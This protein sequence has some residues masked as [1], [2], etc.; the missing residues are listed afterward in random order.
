MSTTL[1]D[2]RRLVAAGDVIVSAHGEIELTNDAIELVDL[3]ATIDDG[4]V[5]E[6][7]PR[8]RKDRASSCCNAT[9]TGDRCTFCGGSAKDRRAPR[10][11]IT[12]YRPDPGKWSRD[13]LTRRS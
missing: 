1:A 4:T 7:T 8:T 13:F 3:R 11:L 12:A 9:Q 6:T 5:V 2:V 10:V